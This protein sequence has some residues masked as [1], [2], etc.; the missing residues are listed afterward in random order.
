MSDDILNTESVQ[1]AF[2]ANDFETK[3]TQAMQRVDAPEGFAARIMDR[4]AKP[5]EAVAVPP[6]PTTGKVIAFR[7]RVQRY[8]ALGLAAML[9]LG[10]FGL[11]EIHQRHER[12]AA[13]QQFETATRIT[14]QALAHTRQQLA[15]AGVQLDSIE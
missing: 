2:E 6:A 3:L 14:D 13:T 4:V 12:E 9:A 8:A 15:K 5:A 7:S 10:V 1:K 11:E